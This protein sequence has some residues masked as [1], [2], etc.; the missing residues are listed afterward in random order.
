MGH[1]SRACIGSAGRGGRLRWAAPEAPG[2][3]H[4]RWMRCPPPSRPQAGHAISS[5]RADCHAAQLIAAPV[6]TGKMAGC[7]CR[8]FCASFSRRLSHWTAPRQNSASLRV[9][10]RHCANRCARHPSRRS[11]FSLLT[12]TASS[13]R[14]LTAPP[15]P[16][17]VHLHPFSGGTSGLPASSS[18]PSS[19]SD[20]GVS[21]S[22][23]Q[24]SLRRSVRVVLGQPG[25][26][27]RPA[28]AR[29]FSA[30][31]AAAATGASIIRCDADA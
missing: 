8:C 19:S 1:P 3:S 21:S 22:S 14:R 30:L 17:R 27:Q 6:S 20:S 25:G 18:S 13:G 23:C 26:P 29:V 9:E 15:V 16:G 11:C 12:D 5:L 31:R 7:L 4:A 24:P 2:Q 10:R 28:T